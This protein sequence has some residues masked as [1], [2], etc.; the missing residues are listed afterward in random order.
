MKL[1]STFY[2]IALVLLNGIFLCPVIINAQANE[3]EVV[4][5]QIWLD[6]YPHFYINKKVEYYGDAGYRSL[7]KEHLWRR[8][9][10]RP[11]VRFHTKDWLEFHAGLGLFYIQNKSITNR[12][13]I[14]P[15]QGVQFNWPTWSTLQFK[16][17]IKLEERIS[18]LTNDWSSSFD[19]RIRY[20]I[21][22]RMKLCRRCESSYWFIPFYSEFFL[23]IKDDI[24]EFFSNRAR[25]GLGIGYNPNKDWRFSILLNLQKSRSTPLENL[26]ITDYAWQLKVRK[27]WKRK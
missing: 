7:P 26:G 6:F 1:A 15:W 19:L 18:F 8:I 5:H 10:A 4:N 11:S 12:F 24:E 20:K 17:M 27:L 22:G 3:P 14:T 25:V 9:Y 21:S 13:E 16:H 23:P 2:L